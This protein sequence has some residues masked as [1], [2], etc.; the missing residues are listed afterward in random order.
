MPFLFVA[1]G[2]P[3]FRVAGAEA[4]LRPAV[5]FW[6]AAVRSEGSGVPAVCSAVGSGVGEVS[7]GKV[8]LHV[9]SLETK[10]FSLAGRESQAYNTSV[11]RTLPAAC[12]VAPVAVQDRYRS[13]RRFDNESGQP[14]HNPNS[15]Q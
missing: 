12:C 6:A 10:K 7:S 4:C 13:G 3:A 5:F 15:S 9:M 11:I 2:V 8:V 1:G 14:P